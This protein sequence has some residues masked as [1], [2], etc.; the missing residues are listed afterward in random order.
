MSNRF[1]ISVAAAALIAGTAFPMRRI[2]AATRGQPVPRRRA[3]RHPSEV[4]RRREQC[5]AIAAVTAA[6]SRT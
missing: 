5:S 6:A 3:R 4:A 1:L 2:Q